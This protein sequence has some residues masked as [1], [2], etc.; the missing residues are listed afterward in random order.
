MQQARVRVLERRSE[1]AEMT[2]DQRSTA[3]TWLDDAFRQLQHAKRFLHDYP[4]VSY[5][6]ATD[7]VQHALAR[8]ASVRAILVASVDETEGSGT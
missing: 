7:A 1:D 6:Q 3:M 8:V 4:V 2:A 5:R